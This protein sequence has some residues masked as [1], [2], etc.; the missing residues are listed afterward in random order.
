[1]PIEPPN[2]EVECDRALDASERATLRGH[3]RDAYGAQLEVDGRLGA[4]AALLAAVIGPERKAHEILVFARGDDAKAV[5]IDYLDGLLAE[6]VGA[7]HGPDEG[8]YLPLG[9]APRDYDGEV[10]WVRGEVRDYLAEEEAARLLGEEPPPRAV[11]RG[12]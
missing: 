11:R 3:L 10:V 4:D 12:D 5:A 1:M 9:W 6:I 7:G 2:L 8:Y